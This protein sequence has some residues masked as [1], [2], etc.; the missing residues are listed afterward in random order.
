MT[1]EHQDSP[2]VELLLALCINHGMKLSRV[3]HGLHFRGIHSNLLQCSG[4]QN[5]AVATVVTLTS[6]APP[7]L[8][9]FGVLLRN[10]SLDHCNTCGD[11]KNDS[12]E[13]SYFISHFNFIL[14]YGKDD[15]KIAAV[16]N[17]HGIM[18]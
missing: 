3:S 13:K 17:I 5:H 2:N 9:L 7:N 1:E 12:E 15:R 11:K 4:V 8:H 6:C 18:V 16:A 14:I 10:K